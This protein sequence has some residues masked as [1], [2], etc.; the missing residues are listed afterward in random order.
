[1]NT[2]HL[3]Q[4]LIEIARRDVGKVEETQ[5]TAP[6]IAKL[7]PATSYPD[8]MANLEPYC[9][10]GVAHCVKVWLEAKEVRDAFGYSAEAAEK[11]RC[12]SAR[13]FDWEKW[14]KQKN[15]TVLPSNCILHAGDLVIYRHS[16]IEIVTDDDGTMKGPFRAI[17]YNTNAAGARDG[18]GCFEK[19]RSRDKVK[20]FIRLLS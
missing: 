13:A 9:A 15:L 18:E 14:A 3:R 1:M 6:W 20:C 5:N 4:K 11:W 16:H 10:A 8:G 7:W 2:F 12:K 19:P 17:G